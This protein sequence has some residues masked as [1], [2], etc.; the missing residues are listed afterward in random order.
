MS[1]AIRSYYLLSTLMTPL[2]EK[3]ETSCA[4][5]AS[6]LELLGIQWAALSLHK[7]IASYVP[8]LILALESHCMFAPFDLQCT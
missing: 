4:L 5:Q 2:L 8:Q 3:K 1:T 7:L 6:C